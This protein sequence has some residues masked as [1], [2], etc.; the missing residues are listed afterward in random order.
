MTAVTKTRGVGKPRM[1]MDKRIELIQWGQRL[2]DFR[3]NVMHINQ[4]RAAAQVGVSMASYV[5]AES[6]RAGFRV[7]GLCERWMARK[8]KAST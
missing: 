1:S 8:L 2:R 4:T 3:E 6:G 7:R 5:N